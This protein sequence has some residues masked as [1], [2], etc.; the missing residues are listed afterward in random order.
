MESIVVFFNSELLTKD[1]VISTKCC[2]ILT[3]F[4]DRLHVMVC[5]LVPFMQFRKREKHP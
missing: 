2:K 5:A 4:Q 3:Q 1:G